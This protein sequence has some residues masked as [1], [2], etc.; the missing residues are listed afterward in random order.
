M[1]DV[2]HRKNLIK[3]VTF[4]AGIYF[5]LEFILPKSVLESVGIADY[6]SQITDG[7]IVVGVMAIGLG[8]INLF[9]VHGTRVVFGRKDWFF[10]AALLVSLVLMLT[11]HMIYWLDGL[12]IVNKSKNLTNLRSF[13]E[14]IVD[15]VK[16]PPKVA[17]PDKKT[18]VAALVKAAKARVQVI[19]EELETIINS[20]QKALSKSD[21]KKMSAS[22]EKFDN[23][24]SQILDTNQDSLLADDESLLSYGKLLAETGLNYKEVL[25]INNQY[26][27]ITEL[28]DFLFE[29]L[30]V[31]L[32]S[33]MFSLL[34][35]YIASA[36]YRAFRVKTLESALMMITAVIVMLG[37]IPDY[38]V[39]IYREFSHYLP[40][41]RQWL[42]ETPNA[43]AFRAI[44]I[45]AAIA[46][47]IMAFR[48]WFSIES[49]S[50][51]K[52]AVNKG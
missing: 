46:G 11:V 48:M 18:R 2:N 7:F 38:N 19:D 35:V 28:Y 26:S 29:G 24:I 15:D 20:P 14:A 1:S 41:M 49:E 12:A 27:F 30:L 13:S 4:I 10:S 52:K 22:I 40:E 23:Q 5:F 3:F 36:A 51:S 33:A 45:G 42:M 50:F 9:M 44:K 47:L 43:A 25:D 31:A 6:H 17:V 21:E 32:G 39:P 34:G 16:S 37:Q 8:I